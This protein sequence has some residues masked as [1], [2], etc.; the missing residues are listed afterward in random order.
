M[1][2]RLRSD[3]LISMRRRNIELTD[4]EGLR[5]LSEFAPFATVPVPKPC[6]DR[7]RRVPMTRKSPTA[8]E[9]GTLDLDQC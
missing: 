5:R 9:G 6:R 2:H 1:L 4:I 8:R 7:S 3:G